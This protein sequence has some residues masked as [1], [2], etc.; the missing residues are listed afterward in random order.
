MIIEFITVNIKFW[1]LTLEAVVR[2]F[3][4]KQESDVSGQFVFITGTG[5]GIGKQ[6]A[7]QYSSLGAKVLCVDVN[8]KNNSQTVKEIKEVGGTAFAYT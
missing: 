1:Y 3:L 8:E 7:L 2:S 5:H 6:L 4:P